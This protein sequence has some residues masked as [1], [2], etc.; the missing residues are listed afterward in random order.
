MKPFRKKRKVGLALGGG[1]SRGVAHI[2]VLKVLEE[3]KI[4]IDM[5]AGT[6]IGALLGA[7]YAREKNISQIEELALGI[8]RKKLASLVDPTLP[9]VGLIAGKKVKDLLKSIIG[10]VKFADLMVPFAC[11]AT[12]IESGEEVVF[13]EG[14]VVEAVRASISIPAVFTPVKRRGRFLVDGGLVNPIPVNVLK[15]M[16]SDIV[17]AVNVIPDVKERARSLERENGDRIMKGK[18]PS[19]FSVIMQMVYIATYQAA[20]FSLEGADIVLEPQLVH[21]GSA[22]FHR[23]Q[24]C[25]SLGEAAIRE[26]LPE[27]RKLL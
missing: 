22:D 5:I 17:I 14:S 13:K 15:E 8:D 7:V 11:V 9:R 19:I 21:I 2:G 27:I 6:S 1:A 25:I 24:E 4:P 10:E 23:A 12:D 16:G 26:A 3:E 20:R 18:S